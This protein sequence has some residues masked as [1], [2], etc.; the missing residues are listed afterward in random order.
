V[1]E[2]ETRRWDIAEQ[3][4]VAREALFRA[5]GKDGNPTLDMLIGVMK[6][7]GVRLSAAAYGFQ[8][9]PMTVEQL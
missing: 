9:T 7:L 4:G 3:A 1:H 6:A 5:L 8:P 2:I